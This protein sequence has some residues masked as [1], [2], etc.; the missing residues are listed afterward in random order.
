M[1]LNLE[2]HKDNFTFTYLESVS[3]M[4][5]LRTRHAV[6]TGTNIEDPKFHSRRNNSQ[7]E[8]KLYTSII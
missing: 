4:S 5:D 1:A 8:D 6:A 7:I 2:K 3:S